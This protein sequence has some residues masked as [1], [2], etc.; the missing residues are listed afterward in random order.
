MGTLIHSAIITFTNRWVIFGLLAQGVFFF[1]FV[2]Q[3]IDSE[4]KKRVVVP[5]AF[6]Y[7]SV[8]GTVMTL[9]Y[10]IHIKDAVF[11]LSSILSFA[12]YFRNIAIQRKETEATSTP[13]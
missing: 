12:I 7:L 6:W 1:R 9:I 5:L 11:I 8:I 3:L 13:Q 2:V 10:S 4:K